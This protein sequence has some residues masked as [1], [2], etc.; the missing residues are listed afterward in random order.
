MG[1]ASDCEQW[2]PAIPMAVQIGRELQAIGYFGPVGIDV[3]R[4]A[5]QSGEV[6]LRCLQD[7]NARWTMGRLALGWK[8]QFQPGESGIWLHGRWPTERVQAE[9][10]R[11]EAYPIDDGIRVIPTAYSA[12]SRFATALLIC[13][14]LPKSLAD[15]EQHWLAAGD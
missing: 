2:A 12:D 8:S 1:P 6:R 7:L 11:R 9:A 3:M 13:A 10:A 14:Q 4:Y 5:H 15:A